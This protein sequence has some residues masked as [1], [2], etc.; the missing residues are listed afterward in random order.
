M[1]Y[2]NEQFELF[3]PIAMVLINIITG[4]IFFS[5]RS[6]YYFA[7]PGRLLFFSSMLYAILFLTFIIIKWETTLA[8]YLNIVENLDTLIRVQ[9]FSA[10]LALLFQLTGIIYLKHAVNRS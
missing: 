9:I 5:F 2:Y 10:L 4:V 1:I 3:F 7:I 8:P 6:K